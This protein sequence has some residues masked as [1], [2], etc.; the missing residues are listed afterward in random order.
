MVAVLQRGCR[1]APVAMRLDARGGRWAVTE[2]S[3]W[4]GEATS[5]DAQE[6]GRH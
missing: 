3:Y 1:V 4:C 5:R 6:G 2:L